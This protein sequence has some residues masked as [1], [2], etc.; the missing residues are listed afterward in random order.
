[1][2]LEFKHKGLKSFAESGETSGILPCHASRLRECL[3]MLRQ[4]KAVNGL[5][6][7]HPM[8][9]GSPLQGLW[10]MRVSAQ[11]RLTFKVEGGVCR[12]I[13]YLNYH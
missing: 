8:A 1:M 13:D 7:I 2:R 11:W 9:P 3:S 6:W 5:R 4:A 12:D 10:A